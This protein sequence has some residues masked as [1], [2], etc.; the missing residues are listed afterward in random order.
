MGASPLGIVNMAGNVSEIVTT[1]DLNYGDPPT[2]AWSG[3]VAKGGSF[4]VSKGGWI[5]LHISVRASIFSADS[6]LAADVGLRCAQ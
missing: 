2:T 6:V 5:D 4:G 3:Y 1:P